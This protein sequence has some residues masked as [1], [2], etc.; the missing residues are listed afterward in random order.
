MF[1]RVLAL[2]PLVLA[3][4]AFQ[5]NTGGAYC[6]DSTQTVQQA[7]NTLVAYNLVNAAAQI[8]GLVG[9]SCNPVTVIGTG[10]GCQA[11]Q[12][13]VCCQ[14]NRENGAVNLGCSPANASV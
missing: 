10:N 7:Q 14:D 2:L 4:S 6:C 3:A 8:G 11:Q 1:A 13:P 9:L 5:C 12:Q